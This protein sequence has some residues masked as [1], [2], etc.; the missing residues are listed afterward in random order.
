MHSHPLRLFYTLF[1]KKR[2]MNSLIFPGALGQGPGIVTDRQ[3][4]NDAQEPT[5][6]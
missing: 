2:K 6:H 1:Q 3:M 5:V 4:E